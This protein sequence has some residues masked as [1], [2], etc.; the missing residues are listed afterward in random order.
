MIVGHAWD[1]RADA[2]VGAPSA[3]STDVLQTVF[4]MTTTIRLDDKLKARLA[5]V[6]AREGKTAHAFILDAIAS[7][8]SEAEEEEALSQVADRRWARVLATGRTVPWDEAEAWLGQR[9]RGNRVRKPVA[10]KPAR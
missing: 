9:V 7:S 4:S 3:H 10:R 1:A 8:V 2:D 6:A 5:E